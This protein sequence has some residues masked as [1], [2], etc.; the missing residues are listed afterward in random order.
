VRYKVRIVRYKVRIA[1]YKV[2]IGNKFPKSANQILWLALEAI[3]DQYAVFLL[4]V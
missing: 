2:R 4:E 1:R 3:L